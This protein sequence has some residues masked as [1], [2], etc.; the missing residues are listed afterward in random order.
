[1]R[2]GLQLLAVE[3]AA[4]PVTVV[5][6]NV[7]AQEKKKLPV[8]D[9]F[10]LRFVHL[11]VD[12][13]SRIASFLGLEPNHVFE[14]AAGQLAENHLRRTSSGALQLTEQGLEV[15]RNLVATQP[16]I[17]ELPVAFDR[18]TW[19]PANYPE[20]ALVEKK[21]AEEIGLTLLPAS[22]NAE[23]GLADVTAAGM[24]ALLE[25]DRLQ[26][27]RVHRAVGRKHRYL[28]VQLLVYG[29]TARNEIELAVCIDDELS[30]NHGSALD[31][32][33]AVRRLGL[34]VD[35]AEPR[36]LLED[37]L[38]ELR[39]IDPEV[40]DESTE[41]TPG[42]IE[43]A[44][45][46]RVATAQVRSVS[47]FEHADFLSEALE[48]ARRRLLIVSPWVRAAV[49]NQTFRTKL[50]E[51]LRA[52]VQVTIAH[53]IG[54]DDRGSDRWAIE[55]LEK[56]AKRFENFNFVRLR[57]THA[58]I[59]IFDDHWISTSFNW[60]SF[61]GDADRTYRMEE[62]TLVTV[63]DRVQKQ[64]DHYLAMIEEQRA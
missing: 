5:R 26:I 2:P 27:L 44:R 52:G 30:P 25:G 20:R 35:S 64:Y 19:L 22:R 63:A 42:D 10:V 62:G 61:R 41:A 7:L 40:V 13:P 60:L 31:Q 6:A 12:E 3:D 21:R 29:D 32:M 8:T 37:D 15:V 45:G 47:V 9:E 43:P 57:N 49:V 23:I 36:P 58:K 14:A 59:L 39:V 55:N 1:M 48:S 53:G 38:E 50:E 46:A 4:L 28:Q 54:D 16:V 33:D 11:G 51:R 18:L 56:L 24:N 17:R 34:S